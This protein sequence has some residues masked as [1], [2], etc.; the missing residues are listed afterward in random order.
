MLTNK[1]ITR[2]EFIFSILSIGTLIVASKAPGIIKDLTSSKKQ[3]NTYGNYS[4]G[5]GNK[6]NV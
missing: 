3:G 1:K 2:K 4:Y 6:K 5:G